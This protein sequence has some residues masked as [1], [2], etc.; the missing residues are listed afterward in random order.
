M[1]TRL[2]FK[3]ETCGRLKIFFFGGGGGGNQLCVAQDF[4]CEGDGEGGKR[5][6][7]A[8][9]ISSTLLLSL[10]LSLGFG[11]QVVVGTTV[12]CVRCNKPPLPASYERRPGD[13]SAPGEKEED[14]KEMSPDSGTTAAQALA[15]AIQ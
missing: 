2:F 1:R 5:E 13:K 7:V 9:I 3:L 6:G 4:F 11:K 14:K 15:E 8:D 10:S 12:P